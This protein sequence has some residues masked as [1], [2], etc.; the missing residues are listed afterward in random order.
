MSEELKKKGKGFAAAE[1]DPATWHAPGKFDEETGERL[2]GG[3][4]GPIKYQDVF[5]K[6]LVEL[7]E[8][9]DRIVGITAAMPSGTSMSMMLEAMPRRAFD[10][11]ISEG[12]AVTLRNR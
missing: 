8:K 11:G 3:K 5:G 9:N 4:G 10:V 12:H 1:A 6:T 7:A 2:K